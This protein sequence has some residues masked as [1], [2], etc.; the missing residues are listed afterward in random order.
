[1][2]LD[3][4]PVYMLLLVF[5]ALLM[6]VFDC[7]QLIFKQRVSFNAIM[8]SI[9]YIFGI[10][11]LLMIFPNFNDRG[12]IYHRLAVVILLA[13]SAFILIPSVFVKPT[14]N[15]LITT[16]VCTF[17]ALLM[18]IIAYYTFGVKYGVIGGLIIYLLIMILGGAILQNLLKTMFK[19]WN[20]ELYYAQKLWELLNDRKLIV[21]VFS[22]VSLELLL[23]FYGLTI[24][25][26][27]P[28]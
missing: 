1:M 21:P 18:G 11:S 14:I 25:F 6:K 15:S 28:I 12:L 17:L 3:I 19:N 23:Q 7:G 5:L 27:L 4:W 10:F 8:N 9:Y 20:N 13:I 24:L 22:L 16:G 2:I 26:F